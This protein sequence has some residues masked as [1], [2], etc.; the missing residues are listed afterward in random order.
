M[1][2][3]SE[4]YIAKARECEGRAQEMPPA[5]RRTF[6]TLAE[7]WR[8]LAF[9]AADAADRRRKQVQEVADRRRKKTEGD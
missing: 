9:D 6:R 7:H 3:K 2:S 4:F 8:E 1:G 5:F